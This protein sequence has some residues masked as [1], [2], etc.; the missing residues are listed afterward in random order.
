M[1]LRLHKQRFQGTRNCHLRGVP[2]NRPIDRQIIDF[3]NRPIVD[4]KV[5]NPEVRYPS[6]AEFFSGTYGSNNSNLNFQDIVEILTGIVERILNPPVEYEVVE[7]TPAPTGREPVPLG[8]L[9]NT[10]ASGVLIPT[11]FEFGTETNALYIGNKKEGRHIYFKIGVDNTDRHNP[12]PKLL[13]STDKNKAGHFKQVME[14]ESIGKS[15]DDV[16]RNIIDK[17]LKMDAFA[18]NKMLT[19]NYSPL[20]SFI[21]FLEKSAYK[22]KPMTS[23]I[24]TTKMRDADGKKYSRFGAGLGGLRDPAQELPYT[25]P[26]GARL[27]TDSVVA[28]RSLKHASCSN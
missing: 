1:K 13:C 21:E 26:H 15:P 16:L 14:Q 3:K 25:S 11:D 23:G 2:Q 12:K 28:R 20:S 4:F 8:D 17:Y 27:L 6:I 10:D 22:I 19:K 7:D 24:E 9:S 18:K 5:D